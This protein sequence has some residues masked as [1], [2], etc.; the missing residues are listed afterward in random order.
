MSDHYFEV[1]QKLEAQVAEVREELERFRNTAVSNQRDNV[2][3]VTER[4]ELRAEVE[5][6]RAELELEHKSHQLTVG[7]AAAVTTRLQ[8]GL[9]A[10]PTRTE[11]CTVP[12]PGWSCSRLAGHDGPCAASPTRTEAEQRVLDAQLGEAR[13]LVFESTEK[14]LRAGEWIAAAAPVLDA[15]ARI[16]DQ[17]LKAWLVDPP[18]TAPDAYEELARAELARRE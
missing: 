13:E 8:S 6:L 18:I 7:V 10:A 14:L 5:R 15:F 4:A 3:L 11:A 1:A 16:P 12:P 2:H 17:D 9:A